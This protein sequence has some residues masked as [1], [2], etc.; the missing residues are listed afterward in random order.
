MS[1]AHPRWAPE[2]A[3]SGPGPG[4]H[5]TLGSC[6]HMASYP[7]M[8][9]SQGSWTQL[10]QGFLPSQTKV[11]CDMYLEVQGSCHP[12]P[13]PQPPA[14]ESDFPPPPPSLPSPSSVVQSLL[15]TGLD[16]LDS[17]LTPSLGFFFCTRG[18]LGWA[19]LDGKTASRGSEVEF[20]VKL[21]VWRSLYV[22]EDDHESPG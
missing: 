16:P 21:G 4:R 3:M 17:I 10:C 20:S 2:L 22:L 15:G 13:Q 6:T 19:P 9:N 11:A 18:W 5:L 1:R 14:E 8:A 7:H 12:L